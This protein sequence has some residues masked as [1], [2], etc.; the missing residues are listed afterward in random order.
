MKEDFEEMNRRLQDIQDLGHMRLEKLQE[1]NVVN[2]KFVV[3]QET[4]QME[5]DIECLSKPM[6]HL[7][8]DALILTQMLRQ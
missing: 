7:Q 3:I 5:R 2:K 1:R 4:R 6:E 8:G